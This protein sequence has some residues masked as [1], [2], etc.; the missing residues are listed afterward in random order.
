MSVN[1]KNPK[2]SEFLF[3][4]FTA[5]LLKKLQLA[6]HDFLWWHCPNGEA[7]GKAAGGRLKLMGVLPGVPDICLIRHGSMIF[8]ELKWGIGGTSKAQDEFIAKSHHHGFKT[9]VINDPKELI[10]T[11]AHFL[12]IDQNP[13]SSISAKML[14]SSIFSSLVDDDIAPM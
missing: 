5:S 6:G 9:Y 7:R 1:D 11:L 14:T 10:P 2:S 13:I 8:I 12:A 3:H 4:V